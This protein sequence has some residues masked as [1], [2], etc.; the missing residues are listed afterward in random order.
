LVNGIINDKG[1]ERSHE[2]LGFSGTDCEAV[3]DLGKQDTISNVTA[4]I[5][6]E[7]ITWIWKPLSFTV[8]VSNDGITYLPVAGGGSPLLSD[9]NKL[10][11]S[12]SSV[13]AR[14]VKVFLMN[15]GTIPENHPGAGSKA[16]LFVSE[17]QVQ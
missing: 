14:Y 5:V 13:P 11:L 15:T 1:R 3:I 17:L 2:I 7:P 9:M 12:F 16:W 10:Q 6:H 8:Q 4:H